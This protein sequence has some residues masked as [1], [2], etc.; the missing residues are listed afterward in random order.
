MAVGEITHIGPHF[1][2]CKG[3]E[4]YGK[5]SM[6][7]IWKKSIMVSKEVQFLNSSKAGTVVL[8][9]LSVIGRWEFSVVKEIWE[10]KI[11][12]HIG[13]VWEYRVTF[14]VLGSKGRETFF[15]YR[16][17]FGILVD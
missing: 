7:I 12:I 6:E 15:H 5:K 9:K 16:S 4:T 17:V 11:R 1:E 14:K 2:H 10:N 3:R 8:K 13:I